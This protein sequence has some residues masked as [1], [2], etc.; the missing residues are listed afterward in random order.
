MP[1]WPSGIALGLFGVAL[2][3]GGCAAWAHPELV[4]QVL[5]FRSPAHPGQEALLRPQPGPE[6]HPP[7]PREITLE[8]IEQLLE[9]KEG[10]KALAEAQVLLQV[11]ID[12]GVPEN[13][14]RLVRL[15]QIIHM[16]EARLTPS[17]A[18]PSAITTQFRGILDRL[19]KS[20]TKRDLASATQAGNQAKDLLQQHPQELDRFAQSYQILMGI[21]RELQSREQGVQEIEELLAKAKQLAEGYLAVAVGNPE[22][23]TRALELQAWARFLTLR[24]PREAAEAKTLNRQAQDLRT[25]LRFA[26]GKRAVIAA[27][28]C[29]REGD[30]PTRDFLVHEARSVLPALLLADSSQNSERA[31]LLREADYLEKQTVSGTNDSSFLREIVYRR[32]YEDLLLRFSEIGQDAEGKVSEPSSE[33]ISEALR[34]CLKVHKALEGLSAPSPDRSRQLA[35]VVFAILDRG[36]KEWLKEAPG[37][38]GT[39]ADARQALTLARAWKDDLRWK[40]LDRLVQQAGT[41]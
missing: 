27:R 31:D 22:D 37:R 38:E 30:Q 33:D 17:P 5:P 35:D 19:R 11:L 25:V 12:Q 8:D 1:S 9:V 13:D 36:I 10:L 14:P 29:L 39:L 2:L 4:R 24:T 34:L 18:H 16:L 26:R 3:L 40:E 21:L 15:R 6:A 20:L 28:R 41:P 32:A 7:K 23:V